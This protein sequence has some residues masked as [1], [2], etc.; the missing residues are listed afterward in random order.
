MP[1]LTQLESSN[2]TDNSSQVRT[3]Y[4]AFQMLQSPS[5]LG[6]GGNAAGSHQHSCWTSLLLAVIAQCWAIAC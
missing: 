4:M 5:Q 1:F 2:V 6:R 3:G